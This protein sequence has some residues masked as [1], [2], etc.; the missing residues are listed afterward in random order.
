MTVLKLGTKVRVAQC[1]LD[2]EVTQ[3]YDTTPIATI[4]NYEVSDEEELA[5]IQYES[6]GIDYVPQDILE[7]I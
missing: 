2:D 3:N 7:P 6:G 5:C 4:V 1:Y